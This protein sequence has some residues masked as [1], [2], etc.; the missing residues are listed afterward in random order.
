MRILYVLNFVLNSKDTN[1]H[2]PNMIPGLWTL[3]SMDNQIGSFNI[4]RCFVP[5]EIR[6][7]KKEFWLPSL[8]SEDGE[9]KVDREWP[10]AQCLPCAVSSATK[11]SPS[12]LKRTLVLRI[13]NQIF[14]LQSSNLSLTPLNENKC[15]WLWNT[16]TH[17]HTHTHTPLNWGKRKDRKQPELR[18]RT[19]ESQRWKTLYVN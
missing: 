8:I 7:G 9:K 11:R 6:G 19:S 18:Q 13:H 1:M 12:L 5:G 4:M 16:H 15:N 14:W 10:H 3:Q 17:T 2:K